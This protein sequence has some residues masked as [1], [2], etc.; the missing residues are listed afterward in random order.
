[1]KTV[2]AT[3]Q[4]DASALALTREW[5]VGVIVADS[6]FQRAPYVVS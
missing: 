5:L 4:I 2:S 6:T 3:I 1:M